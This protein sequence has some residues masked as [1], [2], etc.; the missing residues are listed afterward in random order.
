[1]SLSED[2]ALESLFLSLYDVKILMVA[3]AFAGNLSKCGSLQ[4]AK[5]TTT[6]T[7]LDCPFNS[8][9]I[10]HDCSW[11]LTLSEVGGHFCFPPLANV[12]MFI[13]QKLQRSK[14]KEKAQ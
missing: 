2:H 7:N 5:N 11:S 1:M 13:L 4:F 3:T 9:E 8:V 12:V 14:N 10:H 6:Q